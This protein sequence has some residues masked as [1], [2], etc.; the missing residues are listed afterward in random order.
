MMVA[1][2]RFE[3]RC[4]LDWWVN[5]STNFG[6]IEVSVVITAS[7]AGWDAHGQLTRN[8]ECEGFAFL[9]ALDPVFTL[10]FQDDSTVQVAVTPIDDRRFTLTEDTGPTN[11]P[12]GP[13]IDL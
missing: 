8:D 11:R 3:G 2:D 9:C 6:D 7:Q 5:R 12:V 4:W 13:R 1:M 10:R